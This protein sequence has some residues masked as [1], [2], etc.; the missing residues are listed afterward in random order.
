LSP[1]FRKE[2]KYIKFNKGNFSE[3]NS[4]VNSPE[5]RNEDMQYLKSKSNYN[6]MNDSFFKNNSRKNNFVPNSE[7]NSFII[8]KNKEYNS[9]KRLILNTNNNSKKERANNG[10]E[11]YNNSIKNNRNINSLRIFKSNNLLNSGF[12]SNSL[13]SA[14]DQSIIYRNNSKNLLYKNSSSLKS[15]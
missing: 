10:F 6:K 13:S 3:I 11:I 7:I 12:S 15:Y 2:I 5:K 8:N 9:N 1:I 14:F 4:F